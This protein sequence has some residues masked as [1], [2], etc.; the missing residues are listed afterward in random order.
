MLYL[1]LRPPG[2]HL[3]GCIARGRRSLCAGG[4]PA[5][6]AGR[7]Q[8]L[9]LY[10]RFD[11]SLLGKLSPCV[12]TCIQQKSEGFGVDGQSRRKPGKEPQ[13]TSNARDLARYPQALTGELSSFTDNFGAPRS[14]PLYGIALSFRRYKWLC[15][16]GWESI[17]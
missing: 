13:E 14:E 1:S 8:V 3:T 6:C 5:S 16:G 12:W 10:A 4:T 9:R 17:F 11:R 15:G 7:S 2:N